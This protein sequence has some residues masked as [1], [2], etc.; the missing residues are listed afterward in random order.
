MSYASQLYDELITSKLYKCDKCKI[1][2][3]ERYLYKCYVCNNYLCFNCYDNDENK[4][5]LEYHTFS[6]GWIIPNE[7]ENQSICDECIKHTI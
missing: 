3:Y 5:L 7:D 4:T 1:S 2:T 6:Y